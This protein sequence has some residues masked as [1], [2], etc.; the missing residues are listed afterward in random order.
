MHLLDLL[1]EHGR[2]RVHA[3]GDGDQHDLRDGERQRQVDREARATARRAID[4][5][6]AAELLRLGPDDVHA[7]AA[8][9]ELGDL[10][11]RRETRM[12]DQL[13]GLRVGD[14][15]GADQPELATLHTD[16]VEVETRAVVREPEHDLVALLPHLDQQLAGLVLACRASRVADLDAVHDVVAQQVFE[17]PGHAFEHAAVDVDR[18]TADVEVDA[19]VDFLRRAPRD[20]VQALRDARE[21]H[22]ADL[23]QVLLQVARH[24]PLR[25]E[26]GLGRVEAA[27]QMLL[28]RLHIVDRLGHH[29]CQFLEA[30]EAVELERI[31]LLALGVRRLLRLHA[32]LHLELGLQLDL[33][34]L[35]AQPVDVLAQVAHRA[36]DLLHLVLDARAPRC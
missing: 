7:D 13:R 31:E 32:R 9:R 2:Q 3:L 11:R 29:P 35:R 16:A 10:G 25:G 30:C 4:R 15:G 33:A 19:L 20:A 14:A 27:L 26:V 21:R 24:A 6:A 12:E 23:H 1:D 36:L 34:Q 17:R 18:R 8:A 5:D 28:H 22:H